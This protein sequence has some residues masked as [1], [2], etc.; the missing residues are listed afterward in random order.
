MIAEEVRKELIECIHFGLNNKNRSI[1]LSMPHRLYAT[2]EQSQLFEE[3]TSKNTEYKT[4]IDDPIV[5]L[6]S[7]NIDSIIQGVKTRVNFIDLGPGY[8]VK[9]F[10]IIDELLKRSVNVKYYAVDVSP[11]FLDR[12]IFIAQQ[13][14]VNATKL[15][16]RFETLA[17]ILNKDLTPKEIPR[18]IFL[19]LTFNNFP[20]EYIVSILAEITR[21]N[22]IC[23]VCHQP[24]DGLSKHDLLEP[25]TGNK[26]KAFA[27][28]P[29]RIA[30][31]SQDDVTYSPK[32]NKQVIETCFTT[33]H[34]VAWEGETIPKGT[35]LVTAQSYRFP[36]NKVRDAL[37]KEMVIKNEYIDEKTKITLIKLSGQRD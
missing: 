28:E 23:L 2:D 25:Y 32:L 3:A 5:S 29:L 19:G 8:P 16:R 14:D 18:L 34:D 35:E 30:G 11:Y 4:M 26:I 31:I 15:E 21:S 36:S 24:S 33:I 20:L 37:K 10:I 12:A 17:P 1:S 9:S 27:F 22:D 6:L 7:N 13:K